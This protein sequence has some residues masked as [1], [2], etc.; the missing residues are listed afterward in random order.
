M[1]G[2]GALRQNGEVIIAFTPDAASVSPASRAPLQ[3][4]GV[5]AAATAESLRARAVAAARYRRCRRR[6]QWRQPG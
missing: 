5:T 4:L 2:G 3:P 1:Q 6:R